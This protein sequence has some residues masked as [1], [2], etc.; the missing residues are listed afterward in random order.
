M[1]FSFLS[2]DCLLLA[3]ATS[4]APFD[5]S[6]S[7]VGDQCCDSQRRNARSKSPFESIILS[8]MIC[9]AWHL[10]NAAAKA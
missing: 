7:R 9:P 1:R 5:V 6:G 4:I 8:G 3:S 10:G 2:S